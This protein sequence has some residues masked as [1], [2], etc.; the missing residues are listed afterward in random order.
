MSTADLQWLQQA[1]DIDSQNNTT[2][3][4]FYNN[5]LQ[6]QYNT[7]EREAEQ[8][9]KTAEAD[10][11]VERQKALL[12]WQYE[13]DPSYK[14]YIRSGGGYGGYSYGGYGGYGGGSRYTKYGNSNSYGS[15]NV[16][17]DA[18][19]WYNTIANSGAYTSDQLKII[20]SMLEGG[21]T[22][23]QSIYKTI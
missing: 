1:L 7:T 8:A 17:E 13:N 5:E 2:W 15:S 21:A 4:N 12:A 3:N 11:D 19:D 22:I 23:A 10:K 16:S 14:A 20:W 18:A 6:N 9:Y